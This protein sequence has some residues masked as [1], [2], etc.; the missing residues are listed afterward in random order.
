MPGMAISI[1]PARK[2]SSSI[3]LCFLRDLAMAD[4][5]AGGERM[6]AGKAYRAIHAAKSLA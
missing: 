5:R 2:A 3:R 4:D 6:Q 1:R